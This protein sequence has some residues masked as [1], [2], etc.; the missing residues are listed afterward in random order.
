MTS[1]TGLIPYAAVVG[2]ELEE[3]PEGPVTL[4]RPKASNV[5][6]TQIPAVHG[7]V[8]GALLEHAGIMQIL[9]ECEVDRFPKI[10]NISLDYLR[11][12][13]AGQETRARARVVKLG[14]SVTNVRV[15]AWQA[16]PSRP[17]A[18]AH[19]HFLMG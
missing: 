17:V 18:A 13:L 6:N 8:V 7:G 1:L 14:R 9:W 5:G 3:T 16:D 12:C 4:L 11:P 10:I 19:A 2:F 15:E